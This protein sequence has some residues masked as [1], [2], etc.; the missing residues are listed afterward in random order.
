MTK[1]RSYQ[2][3]GAAMIYAT[4][5][6][7]VGC[8]CREATSFRVM[9]PVNTQFLLNLKTWKLRIFGDNYENRKLC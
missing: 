4:Q 9:D 2:S 6:W 8:G 7:T 3:G 5:V 1:R